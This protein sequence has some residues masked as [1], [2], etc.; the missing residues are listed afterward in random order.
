MRFCKVAVCFKRVGMF[1]YSLKRKF[2]SEKFI[3][4]FNLVQLNGSSYLYLMVL[5]HRFLV[6]KKVFKT[7]KTCSDNFGRIAYA[8]VIG[9]CQVLH[10]RYFLSFSYFTTYLMKIQASEITQKHEKIMKI[11]AIF[12]EAL[13]QAWIV[14]KLI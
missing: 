7:F 6:S 2:F 12:S 14:I 8:L 1:V 11:F 5:K 10:E 13:L 4:V 3:P 9:R